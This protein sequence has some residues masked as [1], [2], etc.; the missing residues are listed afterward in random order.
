MSALALGCR[1]A[2][3]FLVARHV[4]LS[5]DGVW[6]HLVGSGIS[7]GHGFV[8]PNL[9]YSPGHQEVATAQFPPL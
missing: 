8:N 6:Y 7:Q 1:L 5:G 4:P 9:L 3:V 2:Y